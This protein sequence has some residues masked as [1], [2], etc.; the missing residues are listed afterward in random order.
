MKF[1]TGNSVRLKRANMDA[2]RIIR[3]QAIRRGI[4]MSVP[5]ILNLALEIG[6]T[7]VRKKLL[8]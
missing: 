3:M 5:A 7:E 6:L 4:D 2:A 1:L 8:K